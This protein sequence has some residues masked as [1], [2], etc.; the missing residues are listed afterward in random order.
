MS[1]PPGKSKKMTLFKN[2]RVPPIPVVGINGPVPA[3]PCYVYHSVS[4]HWGKILWRVPNQ[5]VDRPDQYLVALLCLTLHR[6]A[7]TRTNPSLWTVTDPDTVQ[8][9]CYCRN[10]DEAH[11]S[12]FM[13]TFEFDTWNPHFQFISNNK[14]LE[15]FIVFERAVDVFSYEWDVWKS[16]IFD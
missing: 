2:K 11:I 15:G 12:G 1:G 5:H 4:E 7:N 8:R 10:Y 6:N 14:F 13:T 16:I 9:R 3:N